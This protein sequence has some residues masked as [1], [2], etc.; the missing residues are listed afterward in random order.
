M[1]HVIRRG[2]AD[3]EAAWRELPRGPW[4]WGSVVARVEGRYLA[5]SGDA[6]LVAGVVVEFGRPLH[7]VALVTVRE[8]GTA[9]H[10]W[11]AA[12]IERTEAVKRFLT[13]VSRELTAFGAAEV[14]TTNL[15]D[16]V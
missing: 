16:L 1:P 9:V 3:L 2:R 13:Q 11:P 12:A 7:P 8:D 14:L 6:L 15:P 10:L 4:R 5:V